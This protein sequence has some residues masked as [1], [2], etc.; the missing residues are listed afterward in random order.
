VEVA[1]TVAASQALSHKKRTHPPFCKPKGW[2]TR[3]S[4]AARCT[5]R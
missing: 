1:G 5:A 2:G 4:S 3:K